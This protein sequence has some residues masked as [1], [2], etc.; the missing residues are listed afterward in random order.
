MGMTTLQTL[1]RIVIPEALVVALPSLGNSFIGMVKGT[2]LVFV[3]AT[4]EITAGG[5]LMAARTF[6]YFEMYVSLAI[7]YW[8]I[9]MAITVALNAWERRLRCDEAHTEADR[10]RNQ[11]LEE[12]V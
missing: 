8:G 4:V 11:R 1:R 7:I 3:T 12:K 6:R 2:S 10:D 5:R 9:T